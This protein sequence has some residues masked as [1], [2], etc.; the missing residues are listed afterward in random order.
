MLRGLG[1]LAKRQTLLSNSV[2]NNCVYHITC[3]QHAFSTENAPKALEQST[4]PLSVPV[5]QVWG[6]NTDVGKTLLSA[7][8]VHQAA[9]DG[10]KVSHLAEPSPDLSDG[11]KVQR[12]VFRVMWRRGLSAM[13]GSPW[14]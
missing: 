11:I 3:S 2:L 13:L 6:S 1:I 12:I 8:L 4:V 14:Q 10:S 5:F 7:G 9:K